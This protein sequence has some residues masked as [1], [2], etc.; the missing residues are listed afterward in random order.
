MDETAYVPPDPCYAQRRVAIGW[1]VAALLAVASSCAEPTSGRIDGDPVVGGASGAA[2][3]AEDP[4]ERA[5]RAVVGVRVGRSW[6]SGVIV[7]SVGI[8][9]TASHVL[10]GAI[11]AR[12]SLY[13]GR[14]ERAR[15]LLDN[16]TGDYAVLRIEAEHPAFPCVSFGDPPAHGDRL[17]LLAMTT[18]ELSRRADGVVL[19]RRA[20]LPMT[21]AV[22]AVRGPYYFR[23]AILHTAAGEPG[24]SGGALVD[25]RGRLVGINVSFAEGLFTLAVPTAPFAAALPAF[26]ALGPPDLAGA[27]ARARLAADQ[28]PVNTVAEVEA[29]LAGLVA[30]AEDVAPGRDAEIRRVAAAIRRAAE[31]LPPRLGGREALAW[32]WREFLGALELA[33]PLARAVAPR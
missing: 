8:V 33:D 28:H 3:A 12:V 27:T 5:L 19:M 29:T 30:Y 25:A 16:D 26:A 11:E 6:G 13:D 22:A 2:L 31:R 14:R 7:D 9:L 23:D 10:D 1:V 21:G 17:S 20:S 15:V 18:D 24:D 32:T 4:V